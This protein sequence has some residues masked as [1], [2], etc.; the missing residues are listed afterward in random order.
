MYIEVNSE[1][2]GRKKRCCEGLKN[3][4]QNVPEIVVSNSV[5]CDCVL[6]TADHGIN[7]SQEGEKRRSKIC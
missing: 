1:T 4:N 7:T 5:L 3:I 6:A 2:C